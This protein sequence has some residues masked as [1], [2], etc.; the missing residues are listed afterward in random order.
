MTLEQ[1]RIERGLS[2]ADVDNV[3]GMSKGYTYKIE[4]GFRSPGKKAINKL[5]ILYGV[6]PYEIFLAC[7]ITK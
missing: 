3:L 7:N 5:A 4:S 1:I 2:R 6:E